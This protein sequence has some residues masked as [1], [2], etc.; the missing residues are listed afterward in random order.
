MIRRGEKNDLNT[1]TIDEVSGADEVVEL[2]TGLVRFTLMV[3][4]GLVR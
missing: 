4:V 2:V 1:G 3:E